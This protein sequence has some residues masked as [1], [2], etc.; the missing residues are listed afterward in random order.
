M[1]SNYDPKTG[2][3]TKKGKKNGFPKQIKKET[4]IYDVRTGKLTED[5]K[6]RLGISKNSTDYDPETGKLT[7]KGKQKGSPELF[8]SQ[9]GNLT[10]V[11]AI[12]GGYSFYIDS[13]TGK[14]IE[15][16]K[17]GSDKVEYIEEKGSGKVE[18]IPE[19][20]I[21]EGAKFEDVYIPTEEI[22][23]KAHN[24]CELLR[25]VLNNPMCD[26]ETKAFLRQGITDLIK[27]K[28][29]Q[30]QVPEKDLNIILDDI[31]SKN[32]DFFPE[33]APMAKER[34]EIRAHIEERKAQVRARL[35]KTKTINRISGVVAVDRMLKGI[36]DGLID[37]PETIEKANNEAKKIRKRLGLRAEIAF[38]KKHEELFK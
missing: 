11:G 24:R 18:Y 34:I 13:K 4:N 36:N 9:T 6:K 25:P 21:P 5:A 15:L 7:T 12:K 14:Y 33:E 2:K 27:Q 32:P 35:K 16:T 26:E 20:G 37:A 10:K 1:E 29:N 17:Q 28:S 30:Y 19:N 3:L 31:Y 38:K 22:L 23:E 8:D